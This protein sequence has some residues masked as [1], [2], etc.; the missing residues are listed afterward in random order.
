MNIRPAAESDAVAIA[1]L[2][3]QL[4]YLSTPEDVTR[5]LRQMQGFDH[6][7]LFVAEV[8]GRVAGWIHVIAFS[9]PEMDLH[10]EIGG[11]VV[12]EAYRSRGVGHLL[13]ARAEA[14]AREH[15]CS[16][17]R[18]RCNVIRTWAHNFYECIG[19]ENIKSQH[20]FRKQL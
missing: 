9:L 7:A 4:G 14:W 20:T 3:N 18:V 16:E 12:D 17:I 11:L 13:V 15:E 1:D 8:D 5:R 10:T 6:N 19:Y 2:C